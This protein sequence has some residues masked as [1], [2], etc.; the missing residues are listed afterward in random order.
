VSQT[1][2]VDRAVPGERT[3]HLAGADLDLVLSGVDL[4]LGRE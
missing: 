3:G 2:T 4:F 1:V